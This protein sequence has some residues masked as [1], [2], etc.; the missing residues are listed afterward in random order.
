MAW[1]AQKLCTD[2]GE[3]ELVVEKQKKNWECSQEIESWKWMTVYHGSVIASGSV[4]DME[5]AK[6]KAEANVPASAA[7]KEAKDDGHCGCD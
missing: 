7:T 5:E 1:I 3:Y 4:N 2:I 6:I